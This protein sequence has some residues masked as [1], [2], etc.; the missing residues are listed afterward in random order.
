MLTFQIQS[1]TL[2]RLSSIISFFEPTTD[3]ETRT[4]LNAV[5]LENRNG[6]LF[7]VVS[8]QKIAAV[9]H[10][11]TTDQPDSVAHLNPSALIAL[12]GLLTITVMPEIALATCQDEQ[13]NIVGDCCHWFDNTP[14][15]GWREWAAPSAT[16]S[17]G[18]MYW[19]LYHIE[20]LLAASPS[21]KV[22]FPQFVDVEKP[23]VLRDRYVEGWVGLFIP[24]PPIGEPAVKPAELPTWFQ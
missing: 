19:D 8:N 16:E 2:Q 14:L 10:L 4:L 3:T 22:V 7:A 24:S 18:A 23:I 1:E 5:R 9:E 13:S 17:K 12:Q 11:G 15:D 6:Q 20:T 21:G